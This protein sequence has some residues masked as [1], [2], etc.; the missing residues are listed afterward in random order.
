MYS[1]TYI[2]L[3]VYGSYFQKA[4]RSALESKASREW[5]DST[6]ERLDREIREARSKLMG[7][8][9]ALKSAV[10]QISE[11]VEGKL[12]R[13]ELGPLKE[14]FGQLLSDVIN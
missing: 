1:R 2:Y 7:Q 11:D 6:F 5:V 10:T 9:E 8:E 13:M 3:S 4:D 12:D 14:Y